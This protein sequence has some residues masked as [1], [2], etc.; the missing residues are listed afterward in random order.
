M[1]T[2]LGLALFRFV[3]HSFALAQSLSEPQIMVRGRTRDGSFVVID[4][5]REAYWWLKNSTPQDAR[6]MAW[7][8]YGY[9]V[10]D[11]GRGALLA[12]RP[13]EGQRNLPTLPLPA[14]RLRRV[15]QGE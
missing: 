12:P 9:Q 11:I 7:W 14:L 6:I 10:R 8:D 3:P 15:C 4:D 2:V 1:A 13:R 5:F